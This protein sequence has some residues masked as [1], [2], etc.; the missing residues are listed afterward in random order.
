MEK[1][2][3]A[4]DC[5]ICGWGN[6]ISMH[7][8][9]YNDIEAGQ[10]FTELLI[11]EYGNGWP[12]VAHGGMVAAVLDETSYRSI[13]LDGN[14]G[15]IMATAEMDIRFL[16][17][18]PTG[19]LLRVVGWTEEMDDSQAKVVGEIRLLDGTVTARCKAQLIK[20]PDAFLE[21]CNYEAEMSV[22]KMR[23]D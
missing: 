19:T 13:W 23:E 4:R 10:V 22:W 12:G 7:A 5:F 14:Y 9:F 1:Q 6:D 2:M 16:R 18:T 20:A 17:P 8:D 11:P 21:K 3:V 15:R